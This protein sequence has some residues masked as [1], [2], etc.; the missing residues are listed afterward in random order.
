MCTMGFLRQPRYW[1]KK[2]R[3]PHPAPSSTQLRNSSLLSFGETWLPALGDSSFWI[4]P[5]QPDFKS[6]LLGAICLRKRTMEAD[7]GNKPD[8][9]HPESGSML[10]IHANQLI[11]TDLPLAYLIHKPFFFRIVS[12]GV[13]WKT[14]NK[15]QADSWWPSG[16]TALHRGQAIAVGSKEN[17]SAENC[18]SCTDLLQKR[19]A[20]PRPLSQS[21][22][23]LS[24]NVKTKVLD[25][26]N[27]WGCH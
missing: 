8:A 6:V 7:A 12:D 27:R 21:K 4:S 10:C 23:P 17:P 25:C 11:S 16:Q 24:G 19:T 3:A 14:Q 13:S 22:S 5:F 15:T 26:V 9:F 2:A 18:V 1:C 20:C